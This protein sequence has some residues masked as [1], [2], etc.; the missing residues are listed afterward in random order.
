[1]SGVNFEFDAAVL[2]PLVRRIV[3]EV[4]A[5]MAA[6]N[7]M[8]NGRLAHSESEAAAL[9]GLQPWQL[10]DERLRHRIGASIGPGRKIMYSKDDLLAYLR[11]RRWT[12]NGNK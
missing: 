9:L 8:F 7:A 10:R 5:A 11:S 6:D 1:M 3:E 2:E 12:K 4:V